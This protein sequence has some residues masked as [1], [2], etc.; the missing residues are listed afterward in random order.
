ME[1][2]VENSGCLKVWETEGADVVEVVEVVEGVEMDWE[3]V[4]VDEHA[5][6]EKL[7][8]GRE[9]EEG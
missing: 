6:T 4:E 5:E 1:K 2:A 8:V 7:M 9:G 3:E